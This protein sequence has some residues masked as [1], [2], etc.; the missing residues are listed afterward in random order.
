MHRQTDGQMDAT[1]RIIGSL[2][3][4]VLDHCQIQFP[5]CKNNLPIIPHVYDV[6]YPWAL[7][8]KKCPTSLVEKCLKKDVAIGRLAL[9]SPILLNHY[10][11]RIM[12]MSTPS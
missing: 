7:C 8:Y 12:N 3:L 4:V 1:K 9:M 6:L 5:S 10:T 11:L 2:N